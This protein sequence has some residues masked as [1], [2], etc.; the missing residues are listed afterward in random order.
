MSVSIETKVGLFTLAGTMLFAFG[1]LVLGDVQF[2]GTYPLYVLFDSAE[3][4]PEKG[5]VKVAGV[6]VGKVETIALAGNRARVKV[7]VRKT[8]AVHQGARARVSSTGLIG[9]KYLGLTLGDPQGRVLAPG[10]EIEGTASFSF[11]EVMS[12]LGDLL[13]DDPEYGS[14]TK[15]LRQTVNNFQTVSKALADSIGQQRTEIADIVRN[16]RAL[17]ANANRVAA[18]LREITGERKE[19]VKIALANFRSISERLD[20]IAANVEKGEGLLG[21]LVNDPELGKSLN[22][23][24]G[25]VNKATKDLQGFT[26]R[27]ASIQLYWDYRQRFDMEDDRW[28]PDLGI[29]MY[30]RPGKYYYLGGNNLGERQDRTEPDTD[31]EKRNTIT[32]VMGHAFGPVTLYGGLLR[33]AGGA[34]FKLR[35]LPAST[36]WNR[37]LELE[38]EAYNFGRDE[39]FQGQTFD[40]PVYN[41]GARVKAIDP[42]LWIGAQVED[43]AERKNFTVNANLVF[44]D[45]DLAFLLA[46]VGLA[47]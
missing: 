41:V 10:E 26:N 17:S 11:D 13:K 4:L 38:A 47:R 44:Q 12:K 2:H 27:I 34:G 16:I 39:S 3:G 32:A 43:V 40:K 14:L 20:R 8:I 5:P 45:K 29:Y 24:M 7:R 15:N 1:V 28:H 6:E 35:P 30:P 42:W 22:E 31:L 23:T 21:R 46:L 18:D 33:S 25:N 37:R 19:D 36:G 9:S